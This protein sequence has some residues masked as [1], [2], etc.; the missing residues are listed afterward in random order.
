MNVKKTIRKLGKVL[1]V[2]LGGLISLI[3][4]ALLIIRYNSTGK[5]E[6]ILDD[7]GNPVATSIAVIEDSVINGARQRLIIRGHDIS[8]PVLLRIHGGPGLPHA[9]QAFRY[10]NIDLE[11]VFTVCYWDQ[12]GTG[13]AYSEDFPDSTITLEQI[14]ADGISVSEYLINRFGKESIYIEG[15]SW[16]TVVG[17]FMAAKRP[18]LFCAYIGI[19]QVSDKPQNE[20]LSYKFVMEEA[21]NRNDTVAIRKLDEIGNPPYP[22]ENISYAIP[23]QRS[24]VMKYVPEKLDMNTIE[25]LKLMLLY[26]GW[27]FKYKMKILTK[28]M[29][30]KS[31]PALWNANATLNLIDEV[32]ELQIPVY[33]FQGENDHFTETSLAREY[34]DSLKA[35]EKKLFLFEDAGHFVSAED[36]EK[37]RFLVDNEILKNK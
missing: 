35:P 32:P 19:G 18:E 36:P 30:A 33:I 22:E 2:T 15:I 20:I 37:Y 16:G 29:Y 6:P 24:Y 14:V 17:T 8:N 27:S 26:K 10:S 21:I 34:F 23:L 12:R 5:A 7:K 1:L 31:T 28:G 9:P 11:D 4:I 3:A 25:K 13:P